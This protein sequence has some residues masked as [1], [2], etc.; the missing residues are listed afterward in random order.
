MGPW[1]LWPLSPNL[2]LLQICFMVVLFCLLLV[3]NV[4]PF[5]STDFYFD[6][7]RTLVLPI[8]SLQQQMGL[9]FC[10]GCLAYVFLH[11]MQPIT[12]RA[13]KTLQNRAA[14]RAL[15]RALYCREGPIGIGPYRAPTKF[16]L[17]PG[18][19]GHPSGENYSLF[20]DF[21][22]SVKTHRNRRILLLRGHSLA[23]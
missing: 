19:L 10:G 2:L 20:L 7:R 15:Y 23:P 18:G 11:Y 12:S 5:P 13:L 4:A 21:V 8:M 16:T 14:T 3:I 1:A 9:T 22:F 6:D 17:M